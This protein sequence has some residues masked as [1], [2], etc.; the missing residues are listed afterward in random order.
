MDKV[1]AESS[2]QVKKDGSG[3]LEICLLVSK[4]QMQSP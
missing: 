3:P 2:R 1:A 4:T